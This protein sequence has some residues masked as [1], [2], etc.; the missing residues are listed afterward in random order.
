MD[1][2]YEPTSPVSSQS[3]GSPPP[4]EIEEIAAAADSRRIPSSSGANKRRGPPSGTHGPQFAR[5]AKSR[6]REDSHGTGQTG[7][8]WGGESKKDREELVDV[9]LAEYLRKGMWRS[10]SLV[11]FGTHDNRP[12]KSG[13]LSMNLSSRRLLRRRSECMGKYNDR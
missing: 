8:T 13:T 6:R 2:D 1:H 7:S 10:L 11:H 12:Q 3:S 5:D 4:E 9:K